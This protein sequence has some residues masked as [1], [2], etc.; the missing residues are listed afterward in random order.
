MQHVRDIVV[1]ELSDGKATL[2]LSSENLRAFQEWERLSN[3]D[4]DALIWIAEE[5]P[6]IVS[7]VKAYKALGWFGAVFIKIGLLAGAFTGILAAIV[8]VQRLWS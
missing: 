1:I 7:M 4:K 6:T 2:M 5:H 8:A 3:E